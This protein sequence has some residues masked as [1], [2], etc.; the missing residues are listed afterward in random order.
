[1]DS[2]ADALVFGRTEVESLYGLPDQL[3]ERRVL[4]CQMNRWHGNE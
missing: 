4:N 2:E 3:G 1:M